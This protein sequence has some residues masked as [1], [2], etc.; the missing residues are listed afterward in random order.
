[1][2]HLKRITCMAIILLSIF[3]CKS[4]KIAEEIT[5]NTS[6]DTYMLNDTFQLIIGDNFAGG[7]EWIWQENNSVQLLS[8]HDSLYFNRQTQ[9]HE[10]A[11]VCTFMSVK[12]GETVLIFNKKRSFEPDSLML[13]N[14]FLKTI[15]IK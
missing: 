12:E 11:L 8:S 5:D 9:L 4:Y 3:N 1:M 14:A 7:Y 13:K 15:F 6:I 2:E 10:H